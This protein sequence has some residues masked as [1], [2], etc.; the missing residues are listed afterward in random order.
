MHLY[1]GPIVAHET[2]DIRVE[3]SHQRHHRQVK[4]LSQ[5]LAADQDI[6]IASLQHLQLFR[7]FLVG[8]I[9]VNPVRAAPACFVQVILEI[10]AAGSAFSAHQCLLTPSLAFLDRLHDLLALVCFGQYI[11]RRVNDSA[12]SDH[13]V[14]HPARA[15]PDLFIAGGG[16]H[17]QRLRD[18]LPKLAGGE[19]ASIVLGRMASLAHAI[20]PSLVTL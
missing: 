6:D 3:D 18:A 2:P 4:T 8:K 5:Q 10:F 17:E 7:A 1:Q 11:D 13:H 14:D 20:H 9:A 12:G 19:W 15:A 16:G